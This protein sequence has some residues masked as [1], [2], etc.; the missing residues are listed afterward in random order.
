MNL[1]RLIII[2]VLVFAVAAFAAKGLQ[3]PPAPAD[4]NVGITARDEAHEPNKGFGFVEMWSFLTK[5]DDGIVANC[6]FGITNIGI[7]GYFP[8]YN[9]TVFL[10]GGKQVNIYSEFKAKDLEIS[11]DQFLIKYP[12]VVLQGRHPAYR[13]QLDDPKVKMDLAFTATC[14]GVKLA[15]DGKVLFGKDSDKY[16]KEILMAPAADVAGTITL[17]GKT[18]AFNG[19]GYVEH[20]SANTF[21]PS[22]AD[23]WYST[24]FHGPEASV[25]HSGFVP[26]DDYTENY[27]GITTVVVGNEIKRIS[28]RGRLELLETRIDPV[29]R[30]SLPVRG[31]V[32]IDEPGFHLRLPIHFNNFVE[33][34]EALAKI[35]VVARKIVELLYARPYIYRFPPIE[36][37]ANLNWGEGEKTCSGEVISQV[38]VFK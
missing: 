36:T 12:N 34:I 6:Q 10:P 8:A 7:T 2:F 27:F 26:D 4:F 22:F 13:M 31:A 9:I 1:R 23:R 3:I 32:V 20:A 38:V 24:R 33:R 15:G 18:L 29:S 30:Y 21:P 17:N 16:Y 28:T 37:S 25:I 11:R 19:W 5:S 35:N 14:P